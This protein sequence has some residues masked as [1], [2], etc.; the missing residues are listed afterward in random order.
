MPDG[1]YVILDVFSAAAYGGNPLAV[2]LDGE[3]FTTAQM[4]T[5]ARELNLS[6]TT[7]VTP[8]ASAGRFAVRIF[9]PGAELPFAG[10]P[11][12]G[13]AI[14][15]AQRGR[16]GATEIVLEEGVGPVRVSLR[17]GHATLHRD[18]A[19]ETVP[20]H[21]AAADIAAALGL[22]AE[23]MAG[24]AWIA[25]YGTAMLFVPVADM[26]A[27]AASAARPDRWE[28]LGLPA[29]GIY[30]YAV[31]SRAADRA[32]LHARMYAPAL[33]VAE[34]PATGAA[35]ASLAGSLPG[36]PA[37]GVFHLDIAQ[38]IEMGRPSRIET[39]TRLAAGHVTGISV[40]GAAVIVGEGRLLRLP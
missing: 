39:A 7:F 12:I 27:V 8:G 23:A 15:L 13:T 30:V 37:D 21:A 31:T 35:A 4:Q 29:R 28:A 1:R 22:S 11:T 19:P 18:G 5:I 17:H 32:S 6:E 25:S 20:V 26:E 38:G 33:G 2:F 24:P 3:D 36:M 14:A 16:T 9:T 40:G 34:D 10:H